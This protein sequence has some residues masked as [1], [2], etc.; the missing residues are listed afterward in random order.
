[1]LWKVFYPVSYFQQGF[2]S[3]T[4]RSTGCLL[5]LLLGKQVAL[6]TRLQQGARHFHK[7]LVQRSA[8]LFCNEPDHKYFR[9]YRS[10]AS[11]ATT[12]LFSCNAEAALDNTYMSEHGCISIKLYLQKRILSVSHNFS[13]FLLRCAHQMNLGLY[14]VPTC[15]VSSPLTS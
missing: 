11:A 1:M 12:Q 8:N 5:L 9:F 7:I 13:F 3:G 4:F 15:F 2:Y 10:Q 14:A 6:L